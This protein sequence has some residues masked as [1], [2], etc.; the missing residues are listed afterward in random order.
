M[1]GIGVPTFSKFRDMVFALRNLQEH[2]TQTW[3]CTIYLK[4]ITMHCRMITAY[5]KK[6]DKRIWYLSDHLVSLSFYSDSVP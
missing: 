4:M 1:Q 6:I 2:Q 3:N 5:L